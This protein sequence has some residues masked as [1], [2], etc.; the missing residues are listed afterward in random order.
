MQE[1]EAAGALEA[2]VG[3]A[4]APEASIPGG[5]TGL[6]VDI[7]SEGALPDVMTQVSQCETMG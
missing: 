5:F 2:R 3:D 6:V 1:L 4:L 7:F